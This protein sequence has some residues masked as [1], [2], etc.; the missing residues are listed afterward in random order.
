MRSIFSYL[1][2]IINGTRKVILNLVFFL[3]LAVFLVSLFSGE[4]PIEV[5][6]NGILV[7]NPNGM[8]VEEDTG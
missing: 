2:K 1:W 4:D 3:I 6:E 8:L 5:P 7:L